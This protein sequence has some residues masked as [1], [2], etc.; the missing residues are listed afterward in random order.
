MSM[1]V[2]A[3]CISALLFTKYF[4]IPSSRHK[5][6]ERSPAPLQGDEVTR[7]ARTVNG[8]QKRCASHPGRDFESRCVSH[9]SPSPLSWRP[10][11]HMGMR[12]PGQP[13]S[14]RDLGAQTPL[15]PVSGTTWSSKCLSVGWS[16][17]HMGIAGYHS[18]TQCRNWHNYFGKGWTVHF[19]VFLF[20]VTILF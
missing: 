14:P 3:P 16:P 15:R 9:H 17:W 4:W 5:L 11:E 19:S 20:F 8:E 1:Q 18:G 2:C 7:P 6:G 13:G 12:S 10:W